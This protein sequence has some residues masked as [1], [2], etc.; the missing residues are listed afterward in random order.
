MEHIP[1]SF[2]CDK[3]KFTGRLSKVMGAGS[4]SMFH[5]MDERNFY[6]GRLRFSEYDNDWVFDPS[7][8]DDDLKQLAGYFGDLVIAW[9]Q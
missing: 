6:R 5:L 4:T 8:K 2:E 7:P 3:K 1:I 9:Y